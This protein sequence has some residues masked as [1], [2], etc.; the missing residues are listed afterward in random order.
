MSHRNFLLVLTIILSAA[1]TVVSQSTPP[2]RS[3]DR[4]PGITKPAAS[5]PTIGKAPRPPRQLP[6]KLQTL[7]FAYAPNLPGARLTVKNVGGETA[8]GYLKISLR[9]A[10]K[11][12]G[13]WPSVT[14]KMPAGSAWVLCPY[15]WKPDPGWGGTQPD[16]TGFFFLS[17]LKVGQTITVNV[18]FERLA[19]TK[20]N[21]PSSLVDFATKHTCGPELAGKASWSDYKYFIAVDADGLSNF[22][23][24]YEAVYLNP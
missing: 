9:A 11:V 15:S 6:A 13:A 5:D 16:L 18:K 17:D 23:P 10:K 19:G 3:P 24:F 12:N 2:Q 1:S 7:S 21:V 14:G 8:G 4:R 22:S 20:I